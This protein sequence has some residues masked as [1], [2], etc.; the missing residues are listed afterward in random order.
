MKKKCIERNK[1]RGGCNLRRFLYQRESRDHAEI[2]VL[3]RRRLRSLL[4]TLNHLKYILRLAREDGRGE[5]DDATGSDAESATTGRRNIIRVRV[6]QP[7]K[8]KD[9]YIHKAHLLNMIVL[10][11]DIKIVDIQRVYTRR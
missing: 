8:Q 1:I 6:H 2:R 3:R 11:V 10:T 9:I 5:R 4:K 7:G